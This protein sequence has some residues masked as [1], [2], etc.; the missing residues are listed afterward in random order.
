MFAGGRR[1]APLSDHTT[2]VSDH[3]FIFTGRVIPERAGISIGPVS[4]QVGAGADL[5]QST[6]YIEIL[7]SQVHARL[8]CPSPPLNI[9]SAR[10]VV[11]DAVRSLLDVGGFI[12][13]RGIDAEILQV[14]AA[15]GTHNRVFDQEIPA[16][17]GLASARGLTHDHLFHLMSKPD[18]WHIRRA[19]S[20]FREATSNPVDTGFF[21]YRA[22][23]T[24]M[25]Y[26]ASSMP[27]A[28]SKRVKWD[29][30]R[31]HYG[32]DRADIDYI[33]GFADP[34]RHGD[35]LSVIE[36]T[37]ANR[38]STFRRAWQIGITVFL[39]EHGDL[40]AGAS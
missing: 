32:I 35:G 22:I 37:D 25:Q 21:C 15:D 2:A 24:L 9:F 10:N 26:H 5:P 36:I 34:V 1:A 7:L 17:V 6:L 39:R 38:E 23:E 20:D 12:G 3:I 4:F 29:A 27:E 31:E 30:F 11:V 18:S 19:L 16:L 13:G 28:T 14:T 8:V 33:K 40:V